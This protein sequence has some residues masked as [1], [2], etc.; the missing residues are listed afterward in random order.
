MKKLRNTIALLLSLLMLFT[1]FAPGAS[2]ATMKNVKQYGADGGYVA[3][4]D[5][6]IIDADADFQNNKGKALTEFFMN[7]VEEPEQNLFPLS[8]KDVLH[9]LLA[10]FN[11]NT[12]NC[13]I[14]T[15]HSPYI[16]NE[17]S[18]AVKAG[19]VLDKGQ[20]ED[21]DEKVGK[22]VPVASCLSPERL[23][24]YEI[25]DDGCVV[26]LPNYGGLPSDDN[27]LNN[28][29]MDSNERFNQLL[30]IEDGLES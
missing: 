7:I 1:V 4:G 26:Q 24:I 28:S 16:I 23:S 6:N 13:L 5:H 2:A 3:F 20:G 30:E 9:S 21:I 8:Q 22:V 27:Y 29:L 25:R 10:V 14:I 11:M 17:L 15:T 18:L 12:N 19:S